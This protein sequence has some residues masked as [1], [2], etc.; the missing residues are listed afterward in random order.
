MSR[1][2]IKPETI[3]RNVVAAIAAALSQSAVIGLPMRGTVLLPSCVLLPGALLAPTILLLPY[4]SLLL[5]TLGRLLDALLL[6]CLLGALL[7][8]L[9]L[10]SP[11]LLL[12]LRLLGALRLR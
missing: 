4:A 1:S 3:L 7:L 12:R 2:E 10:L 8:R 6:R 5:G 11:S 9:R